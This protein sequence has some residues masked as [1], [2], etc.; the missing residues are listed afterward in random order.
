LLVA[1][2]GVAIWIA[3]RAESMLG[4]HDSGKIV[5]DEV[6]GMVIALAWHAPTWGTIVLI[7]L[8]FR[9]C[10]V[11]KIWPANALDRDLPGGAG[12]VL[13]DVVSGIYA[14]LIARLFV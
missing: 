13:D 1:A 8:L 3:G 14:N 7:Y 12:V 4:E 6:V 5:I 10:D 2:V 9:A 11:I